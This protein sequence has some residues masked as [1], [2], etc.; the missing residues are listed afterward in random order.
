[1]KSSYQVLVCF[2]LLFVLLSLILVCDLFAATSQAT[3][4]KDKPPAV[5]VKPTTTNPLLETLL[6]SK[7]DGDFE[8]SSDFFCTL[9]ATLFMNGHDVNKLLVY[10]T[11]ELAFSGRAMAILQKGRAV[12]FDSANQT[13]TVVI[14]GTIPF[15]VPGNDAQKLLLLS[16][17]GQVL[18]TLSCGINSRYGSLLTAYP[19]RDDDDGAQF[20]IRFIPR[21]INKSKWHNWHTV[22][23]GENKYTFDVAEKNEPIDWVN[24]G[25]VR[26][27]IKNGK[28]RI[29]FP[30][31]NEPENKEPKK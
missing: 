2:S 17:S 28:F 24:R 18:D 8:H 9:S 29:L 23:H 10:D 4:V 5:G 6:M 15:G 16:E 14:L 1:M 27:A 13:Y 26:V 25:L 19:K 11:G 22:I 20:V 7:T 31:V 3:P 30:E 21:P 12:K